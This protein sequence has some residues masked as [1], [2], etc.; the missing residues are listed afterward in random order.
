MLTAPDEGVMPVPWD[1]LYKAKWEE[2]ITALGARYDNN[3]RLGYVVMTGFCMVAESYL[4]R[5]QP[6]IDF[7]DASAIAAGYTGNGTLPAGLVAWEATVQEMVGQ[8]MSAFPH[9]PL[10]ITGA[11]PYGGGDSQDVSTS[12]MNDIFDWGV[13]T[14]PGRFG[15]M[16][17]QLHATSAAGYFLNSAIFTNYLYDPT[18]IQFLCSSVGDDNG[19]R[20][21]NSPPYGPDPLLSPY[22]AMNNSFTAAVSFGD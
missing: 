20:L 18:G 6:D 12:A 9:T 5:E 11:Y 3:P 15:I 16:N 14:Y 4:A 17:S 13:A 19:A 2:F 1:P 7:F 22:D 8:Y 10:F 21:S